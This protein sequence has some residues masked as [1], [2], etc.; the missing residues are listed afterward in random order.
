MS[1]V[2]FAVAGIAALS[3]ACI[4][5]TPSKG[6]PYDD[7]CDDGYDFGYLTGES[8]GGACAE[9]N[10]DPGERFD[11]G[12]TGAASYNDGYVDCYPGG[13]DDGYTAGASGCAR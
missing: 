5:G 9:Y 12:D 10:S 8:D 13:Y 6:G 7:G 1:R 3:V 4:D 11:S 2:L